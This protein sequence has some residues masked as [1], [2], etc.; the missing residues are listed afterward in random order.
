MPM[1]GAGYHRALFLSGVISARQVHIL[2]GKGPREPRHLHTEV[3]SEPQGPGC[4]FPSEPSS[5]SAQCEHTELAQLSN[6][7][8]QFS[9]GRDHDVFPWVPRRIQRK[10]P[11]VGRRMH[12]EIWPMQRGFP[13]PV[14]KY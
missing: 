12:A 7:F 8:P 13:V 14:A 11:G 2:P 5:R 1:S 4:P 9:E 3:P 6:H 10:G